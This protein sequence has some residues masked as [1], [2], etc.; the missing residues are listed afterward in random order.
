MAFLT[1]SSIER[2]GIVC[3]IGGASYRLSMDLTHFLARLLGLF[4][5]VVSV[6]MQLRLQIGFEDPGGYRPKSLKNPQRSS[7]YVSLFGNQGAGILRVTCE[8][9]TGRFRS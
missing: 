9:L 1:I 8:C 7:E 2:T 5:I 6:V 3:R 4:C